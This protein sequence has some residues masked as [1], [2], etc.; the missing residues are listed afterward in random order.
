[1]SS[2]FK[3]AKKIDAPKTAGKKDKLEVAMPGLETIAQID[4]LIKSFGSIKKSLEQ[5]VRDQAMDEFVKI[6]HETNARPDNFKGVDGAAK[7]SIE[8]RKRSTASALTAEEVQIL[9]DHGFSPEKK[10]T[11]QHLFGINPAYAADEKLLERV[12]EALKD[13]VPEDFIVEQE[14]RSSDVINDALI[15]AVF[16]K[17]MPREI[18]EM[19]STLAMKPA[20][21]EFNMVEV[22]DKMKTLLTPEDAAAQTNLKVA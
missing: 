12:S 7:V 21:S 1:M 8:L 19:V 11:T 13:I 3:N 20:L 22:L 6:A 10:I 18:I 16:K 14:E 9:K 17:P 5:S 4:A 2:L 15:D